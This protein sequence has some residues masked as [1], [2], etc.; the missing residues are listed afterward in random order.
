[1]FEARQQQQ[2]YGRHLVNRSIACIST[3]AQP[4]HIDTCACDKADV[5]TRRAFACVLLD[6]VK[7]EILVAEMPVGLQEKARR[8]VCL[9]M[10]KNAVEKDIATDVKKHFEEDCAGSWHCV[11]RASRS[12]QGA[13]VSMERDCKVVSST[14]GSREERIG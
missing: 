8:R 2:H 6:A 10:D 14:G 7:L 4:T 5:F 3:D 9:A 12:S 13:V 1:M 11:V